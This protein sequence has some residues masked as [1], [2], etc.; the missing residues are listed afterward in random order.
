L[1]LPFPNCN[2]KTLSLTKF[3]IDFPRTKR[4]SRQADETGGNRV[5][6][7]RNRVHLGRPTFTLAWVWQPYS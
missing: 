6:W 3:R 4:S 1:D 7:N 2:N 5:K